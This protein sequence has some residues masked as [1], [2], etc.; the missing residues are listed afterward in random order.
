MDEGFLP[1]GRMRVVKGQGLYVRLPVAERLRAARGMKQ[2]V[3]KVASYAHG[4]ARAKGLID[5]ISRQGK[6]ELET[7]SGERIT[8]RQQGKALVDNWA[9]DFDGK[10]KSRDAVHLV[11]SM[12][13]GSKVEAL[14]ESVRK[15]GE[16]AFANREWLFAIH[17]DRRHPHA[18]MVVKMRGLEK[19]NKLRLN[20]PELYRLRE[21]F[22]EGHVGGF[23]PRG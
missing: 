22:A 17:E 11:F 14:R 13:P 4:A 10:A 9:R 16:R 3:V 8:D 12:P 6:L 5:Y 1:S 19:D 18:H 23:A 21:V 2:A 15:V 20:K 7:E